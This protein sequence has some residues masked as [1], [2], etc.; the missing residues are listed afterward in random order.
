M[1]LVFKAGSPL[2]PL[3]YNTFNLSLSCVAKCW[4][5]IRIGTKDKFYLIMFNTTNDL[6]NIADMDEDICLFILKS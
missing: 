2:L 6:N 5:L 3:Y 4:K 1:I